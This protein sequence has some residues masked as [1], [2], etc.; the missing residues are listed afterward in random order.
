MSADSPIDTSDMIAV[1]DVFRRVLSTAG[2]VVGRVGA[3]D[4]DQVAVVASYFANVLAFLHVHHEGEDLLLWPKLLDRVSDGGLVSRIAA[5]HDDVNGALRTAELRLGEWAAGPTVRHVSALVTALT[6]LDL[7]LRPHLAEEET[8]IL[9]L[10]AQHISADE[11]AELPAHGV[12]NFS[13]D[14]LWLILG[15]ILE[16]MTPEQVTGLLAGM[17]APVLEF[18]TSFG[19]PQFESFI[20]TVRG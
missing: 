8:L 5:Q 15:L 1:H 13:G 11:W 19:R 12:A 16:A 9:P 2:D 10:A 18:W 3:G 4:D 7:L 20:A 6:T 14:K 17:P